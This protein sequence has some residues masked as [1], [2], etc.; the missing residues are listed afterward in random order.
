MVEGGASL[1]TQFLAGGLVDELQLVIAPFFVGDPAAPR[2]AGPGHYPA[3]P[4]HPLHLA[5]ARPVGEVVLLRYLA[6]GGAAAAPGGSGGGPVAGPGRGAPI[7]RAGGGG[8][9][10]LTRRPAPGPSPPRP[11]GEWLLQAIELSRRCP[12]SPPPSAW[13]R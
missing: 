2:F 10:W 4:A 3:S 1:G 6:D 8:G 12:P 7:A 13:A 5:E 9:A 11:T